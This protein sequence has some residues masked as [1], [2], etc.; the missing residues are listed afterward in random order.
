MTSLIIY[1]IKRINTKI[2]CIGIFIFLVYIL[3]SPV[4]GQNDL[5]YPVET[6][7]DVIKNSCLWYDSG[8]G[9]T[10]VDVL[11]YENPKDISVNGFIEKYCDVVLWENETRWTCDEWFEINNLRYDAR[12]SFF[13]LWLCMTYDEARKWY[14]GNGT[15]YQYRD[16][17][18][19]F[20][21][22][23]YT[24][25]VFFDGTEDFEINPDLL[26][27]FDINAWNDNAELVLKKRWEL[28]TK[29]NN[30]YDRCD[31]RNSNMNTCNLWY[32]YHNI[33]RN[34]LDWYVDLRQAAQTWLDLDENGE[35]DVTNIVT[36]Y[37]WSGEE[38]CL[39]DKVEFI[40]D[41]DVD[42]ILACSMDKYW[43]LIYDSDTSA[44]INLI[45]NEKFRSD[46]W[47]S[48]MTWAMQYY[49]QISWD[50]SDWSRISLEKDTINQNI[51]GL[52]IFQDVIR[53]AVSDT[54]TYFNNFNIA[55]AQYLALKVESENIDLFI[56][57][58]WWNFYT[59]VDQLRT[60]FKNV[61]V[62]E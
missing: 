46:Q 32:I 14:S 59:A 49:P 27:V 50:L 24:Y 43:K 56:R 33:L 3:V 19:L 29:D 16:Y 15:D 23:A 37:F 55:Y 34:M 30:G 45:E 12:Q 53:S 1:Y 36:T 62:E 61:Q 20:E 57:N 38:T 22:L 25:D 39:D 4:Y 47:I 58:L 48:Y 13:V 7:N 44:W 2:S 41:T 51:R 40:Q 21:M 35:I 8:D 18:E 42:T 31:P 5:W 6:N 52:Y 28:K 11:V 17:Q 60:L 10:L 54:N 26:D 9:N